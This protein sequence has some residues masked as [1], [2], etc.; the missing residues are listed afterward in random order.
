M[1]G[2][3][4]TDVETVFHWAHYTPFSDLCVKIAER[5]LF[6]VRQIDTLR[7]GLPGLVPKCAARPGGISPADPL[8]ACQAQ[9]I[10][11][12]QRHAPPPPCTFKKALACPK[13]VSCRC[14]YLARGLAWFDCLHVCICNSYVCMLTIALHFLRGSKEE[15]AVRV[16]EE[17]KSQFET[18]RCSEGNGFSARH[19]S[20][21]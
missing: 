20:R 8:S 5:S 15:E 7:V 9:K 2:R 12:A 16:A 6:A 10:L 21:E 13:G 4:A 14:C 19:S 3:S 11:P 1:H 18:G 17:A